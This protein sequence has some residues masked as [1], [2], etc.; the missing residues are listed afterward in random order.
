MKPCRTCG[1]PTL[2]VQPGISHLLHLVL[3]ILSIGMWLPVWILVTLNAKTE[4]QCTICGR[5]K[6]VFG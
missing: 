4:A 1:K 2:H 3:T 6:G 5:T